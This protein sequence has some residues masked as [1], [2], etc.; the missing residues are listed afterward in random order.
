MLD[1]L[2]LH[3]QGHSLFAGQNRFAL[4]EVV[5]RHSENG[6]VIRHIADDTGHIAIPGKLAGHL[7]AVARDDLIA[8]A[9]TGT[10]QRGLVDAAVANTLHQRFHFRIVTDTE[11]MIL[12]RVQVGKVKIDDFLFFGAGSVAGCRRHFRGRRCCLFLG[13]CMGFASLG[14]LGL[15]RG[16]FFRLGRAATAGL[17][18]LCLFLGPRLGRRSFFGFCGAAPFGLGFLRLRHGLFPF[19]LAVLGDGNRLGFR[20]LGDV[21]RSILFRR[22]T[23]SGKV[24]HLCGR[25]GAGAHIRDLGLLLFRGFSRH[26]RRGL[27]LRGRGMLVFFCHDTNNLL[28][29]NL[30]HAARLAHIGTQRKRC[31]HTKTPPMSY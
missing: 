16:H 25:S 8:A 31:L 24:D 1:G 12:E 7:A 3:F 23:H 20:L 19:L 6:L 5:I 13:G 27:F 15:L 14:R 26:F 17:F 28:D 10:Y 18:R 29:K 22:G 2:I 4:T 9:L 11:R 21:R 30:G